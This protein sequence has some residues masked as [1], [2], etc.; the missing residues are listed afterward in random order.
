MALLTINHSINEANSFIASVRDTSNSYYLFAGKSTSWTN[1]NG[2][3]N[4]TNVIVANGSVAQYEQ[5][6]YQDMLFGK[7]I[8][9]TDVIN[10]AP[11]YNWTTNT[12][13]AVY[14]QNDPILYTKQFYILNNQYQVYK[15]IFNNNGL[16]ST[17]QP[18][19]TS[20][21]GIFTTGDGY[22]WKYMFTLDTNSNTK[23]TTTSFIPVTPDANVQSNSVPGT[24]D[25]IKII[26]G[27]NN[28]QVTETGF[29]N[30]FI[31]KYTIQL[32]NTSSYSD[33]YYTN[34]S[35]YL[36][37]GFGSGQ[38]R[39]IVSSNG[40]AKTVRVSPSSPFN[41]FTRIDLANIV[42][43]IVTGN[44]ANQPIDYLSYLYSVGY[45]NVG[46]SII[47]SDTLVSG[48]II[49]SNSS[50]L[51]ISK[52]D[53][54]KIFDINHPIRSLSQDGISKTGNG[55]VAA[56]G[57]L[58]F[59][60]MLTNGTGYTANTIVTIT[61]NDTGV[62][63]T[64]NGHA[65]TTGKIDSVLIS[66]NGS[67][68]YTEPTVYVNLPAPTTFNSNTNISANYIIVASAGSFVANDAIVY[69]VA[70]GNTP[71][72]GLVSLSTY[73]VQFANSTAIGLS[74][75]I[76]GAIIPLTPGVTETGHSLQGIGAT[77]RI[78]PDNMT[79][80]GTG[81]QFTD[82]ANGYI[83]NDYIRVGL[84]SNTNFRKVTTVVNNTL[85]IV[86][87][88]FS[89][90][91]IVNSIYKLPI[92]AG[93]TSTTVSS[94]NGYV[95]NTNLTSKKI[96]IANPSIIGSKFIIG[97]K[98]DLVDNSNTNVGANATISFSNTTVVYLSSVNGSW[99]PNYN[100]R[101]ES[102]LLL[103]N[104]VS[105]DTN[106][107]VT[108]T[109]PQG[110]YVLGQKVFFSINGSNTASGV[111]V[112]AVNIPNDFTEYRIG[113]TIKISGDGVG[114]IGIGVVNTNFNSANDIISVQIINNGNNYTTANVIVYA[115][116]LYG[117]YANLSPIISPILGH[118]ADPISE[119][120][121]SYVG[122][123]G[124]FDTGNAEQHYFP[125]YSSYR[126][127]GIIQNP[128]FNNII[129]NLTSFD[130]IN[131]SINNKITSSNVATD[132]VVGEVVVQRS[133][134]A[135]GTIA[136]GNSTFLQLKSVLGSF[137][138]TGSIYAY[139]SNTTAN[140][141][142]SNIVMFVP[143]N[144]SEIVSDTQTGGKAVVQLAV[145]NTQILV[146]NVV[147]RF[148]AGDVI[149][150]SSSN[151]SAIIGTI[152]SANN[153]KDV[154]NSF[155][156]K[157]N[158]TA[159]IT[160][161]SV[162]QGS[163]T[164]GETIIQDTS[165]ASGILV[166]AID[167]IDIVYGS[168]VGSFFTGQIITDANTTANG[169]VIFANSTYLKLTGI[170]N[171]VN[172]VVGDTI[173]NGLSSNAV[174]TKLNTVLLLN[175][176]SKLNNFQASFSNN[177]TGQTSGVIGISGD[178]TC[179]TYPELIRNTGKVIYFENIAPITRTRTSK[180]EVKLVIKF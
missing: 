102:S 119:L 172:F 76:G 91:V 138:N 170:S 105:V 63:A 83:T 139:Y 111:V 149:V 40:V 144:V 118:G 80:I 70:S 58:N 13:Y 153:T 30:K 125:T 163:F 113:P 79:V 72:V 84:I 25:T 64:A 11:R 3:P 19:L 173:N 36:N 177:I 66:A 140:V 90:T 145:T 29:I 148:I 43:T 178:Y 68:Y 10:L 87:K 23:F 18:E 45:F 28:Y 141:V 16:P 44:F 143:G 49:A 67:L 32:P 174:I 117:N 96:T 155:G 129:I 107:N 65:N 2:S 168:A 150:D 127:V 123:D 99:V 154:S 1:A 53:I 165:N 42:G 160:L 9:P 97:E 82:T 100:I 133:S 176:V 142:S 146:S 136:Y 156:Q 24:I 171:S 62:G 61:S 4:D 77:A 22:I 147:G 151:A 41:I 26:S 161:Q 6:V 60:L 21:S 179:I 38:I 17:I 85:I 50:T 27:G 167:E 180:E 86:D 109:N 74:S 7:Q 89:N 120:G 106:P 48:I 108:L 35:I 15:C 152:M 116:N 57:Q 132:W 47:Q 37:A 122:V 14:D 103:A 55:A 71:L 159:R 175:N 56:S 12:V 98:V 69:S 88:P 158:Q 94:S 46:D 95:S 81:T 121:A 124:I 166:S 78:I 126:K 135:A 75:T 134:N 114:A 39:Q 52:T 8:K 131:L 51:E 34:S 92:A 162:T 54:T 164:P 20:P 115:N 73:Y 5:S 130:R 137:S 112:N 31:D 93:I 59:S 33:N 169:V 110:N 101:G 157:F 128:Q 104:I